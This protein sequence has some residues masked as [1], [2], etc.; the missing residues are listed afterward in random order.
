MTAI[1]VPKEGAEVTK[2]RVIQFCTDKLAKYKVPKYVE[3]TDE[4]PKNPSGK[5]LKRSLRDKY[6]GLA[7]Q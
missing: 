1:V 3:I 6:E 2:E 7:A 4:L 5:V